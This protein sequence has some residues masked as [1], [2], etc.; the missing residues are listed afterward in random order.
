MPSPRRST[1]SLEP[2]CGPDA[3][4]TAPVTTSVMHTGQAHPRHH[5]DEASS[6]RPEVRGRRAGS[7]PREPRSSASPNAASPRR[8]CVMTASGW[9]SRAI[10][11]PPIGICAIATRKAPSAAH[12]PQPREAARPARRQP[13]GEREDDPD[14]RDHAVAELDECVEALLRVGPVAAA[15]PV[16]AA[17]TRA[18]QADE[19]ARRDDQ[20]Q[21]DARR[22]RDP[23]ERPRRDRSSPRRRR[24]PLAEHDSGALLDAADAR[25]EEPFRRERR[26]E[27]GGPL[28][29]H[30]HEQAPGGLRV[31]GESLP[32]SRRMALDVR[33]R[34]LSVAAVASRPH[35]FRREL[36]RGRKRRELP[37]R[38]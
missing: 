20:E 31:V 23:E 34:V 24:R 29:G 25:G 11:M 5:A 28:A 8:K 32:R 2:G 19:R 3:V 17:E 12:R 21:R 1:S 27:D 26:L 38:R 22:E 9:R 15:R 6:A 33:A 7:M 18:R 35:A 14:E 13:G 30:R 10:V 4:A 36:E 37:Q 16:L